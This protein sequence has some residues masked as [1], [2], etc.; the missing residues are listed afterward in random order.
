MIMM[1][2]NLFDTIPN[3]KG[4]TNDQIVDYVFDQLWK[5]VL[6]G[7]NEEID[8]Q[9]VKAHLCQYYLYVENVKNLYRTLFN[10]PEH[11]Y[12][13]EFVIA[14]WKN[15]VAK[16]YVEKPEIQ[17]LLAEYEEIESAELLVDQLK[18]LIKS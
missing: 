3:R 18:K 7:E 17:S 8:I 1:P 13:F 14:Y 2:E 15:Y 5:P 6:T 11:D 12:P 4:M 16:M 10:L 9:K